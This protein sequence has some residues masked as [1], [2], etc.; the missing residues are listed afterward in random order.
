M[1][2]HAHGRAVK[3]DPGAAW[4]HR[5]NHYICTPCGFAN[6]DATAEELVA[7]KVWSDELFKTIDESGLGKEKG[8]WSLSR[9]AHCNAVRFFG[10]QTVRK[11]R[12]L[13]MKYNP[14]NVL[15]GAVPVLE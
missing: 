4:A 12:D 13:K 11:L 3:Y 9:P 10:E 8:Y 15:P 2:H 1:F 6:A 7:S 14:E 5:E